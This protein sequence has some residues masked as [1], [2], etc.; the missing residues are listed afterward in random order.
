MLIGFLWIKASRLNER[1]RGRRL[2]Q[3]FTGSAQYMFM[4][5]LFPFPDVYFSHFVINLPHIFLVRSLLWF[6]CQFCLLPQGMVKVPVWKWTESAGQLLSHA[7]WCIQSFRKSNPNLPQKGPRQAF[8]CPL[9]GMC[10]FSFHCVLKVFET[11]C[12]AFSLALSLEIV[13]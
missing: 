10:L 8:N 4:S 12:L 9:N 5:I 2:P 13:P 1:I 6:L 7:S 3:Y 11:M